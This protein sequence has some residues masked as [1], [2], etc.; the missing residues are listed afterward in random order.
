M[1]PRPEPELA[2]RLARHVST[3]LAAVVAE[4]DR[5]PLGF[6]ETRPERWADPVLYAYSL[7]QLLRACWAGEKVDASST[8]TTAW[9]TF[10]NEVPDVIAIRNTLDKFDKEEL[11]NEGGLPVFATYEDGFTAFTLHVGDYVLEMDAATEAAKRMAEACID[12][13]A[14]IGNE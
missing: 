10:V 6:T 13:L 1:P 14:R 11:A 9:E 8:I 5:I 4:R 2:R 12:Q 3:W 7:R